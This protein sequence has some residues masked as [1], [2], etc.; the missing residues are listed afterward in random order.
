MKLAEPFLTLFRLP[1]SV[2]QMAAI[3]ITFEIQFVLTKEIIIVII[4]TLFK[5]QIFLAEHWC[6]TKLG[7]L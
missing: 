3:G 1:Y 4:I 7:R 2:I 5:S 6:S